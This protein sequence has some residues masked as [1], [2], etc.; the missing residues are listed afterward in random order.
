[1]K[2]L[3][4]SDSFKVHVRPGEAII[5]HVVPEENRQDIIGIPGVDGSGGGSSSSFGWRR[6][7][8]GQ[9]SQASPQIIPAGQRTLLE[10]DGL[11]GDPASRLTGAFALHDFL[12]QDRM[13][14]LS[15][16]DSYDLRLSFNAESTVMN[17]SI[18]VELDIGGSV[19]VIQGEHPRLPIDAGEVGLVTLNFLM[20]ALDTFQA[21]GAGIYI[22]AD[23]P[24]TVWGTSWFIRPQHKS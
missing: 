15:I 9:Y 17:N 21:N 2:N 13:R 8:D 12:D 24:L 14:S 3:I 22:T 20:Y 23:T 1:M 11:G 18:L 19:G 6:F 10:N 5:G 4:R 7:S 16:G